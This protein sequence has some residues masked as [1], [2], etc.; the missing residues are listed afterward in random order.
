MH[1]REALDRLDAIHDHLA[2]FE[3]YRGFRAAA[4]ATVGV[5]GL[6]AAAA[7]P[8]LVDAPDA[9]VTYWVVVAGF[10]AL[11]GFGP[12]FYSY[13]AVETDLARR[14]TRLVLGQF[15]P[16][17]VAGAVVTAAIVRIGSGSIPLLPGLWAI[18][19]GL[20]LVSARPCLPRA[21]G[22]IGLFY[23]G[24]GCILLAWDQAEPSGWAVGGVFGPGHLATSVVLARGKQE[25][26]GD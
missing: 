2:R 10:C 15:L 14:R 26:A 3:V 22:W 16:C 6:L 18:L 19:F 9:F 23:V 25:E 21:V 20:G 17:V 11:I 8:L 12:A 1:V 13:A 24:A 7:Q 5:I 4:V